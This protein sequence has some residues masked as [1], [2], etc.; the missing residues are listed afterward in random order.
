M[1]FKDI[2]GHNQVKKVLLNAITQ[3]RVA[4]AYLFFGP[5]GIGKRG[6]ATAFAAGILCTT[7]PG[8]A[9]GECSRCRRI[10]EGIYPDVF[11]LS[12]VNGSIKIEQ[13]RGIQKKVQYKPYEGEK[14]VIIIE[15]A[16][17]MTRDAS[18]SLLKILEE[19][20]ED[21]CFILTASNHYNLLPTIVSRCQPI[22]MGK[23][24]ADD[25][26]KLLESRGLDLEKAKLITVFADGIPGR[27]LEMIDSGNLEESRAYVFNLAQAIEKGSVSE[28]LKYAEEL[29]KRGDLQTIL[30]QMVLWYR[31]NLMWLETNKD[32]LIINLDRLNFIKSHKG[33]KQYYIDSIK[34][35]LEA[36]NKIEQNVNLRLTLEVLLLKLADHFVG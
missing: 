17:A 34:E 7:S 21:T 29:E 26:E 9:C 19:P 5:S 8:S 15:D 25:I 1:F 20:P 2:L 23:V 3:N 28:L 22:Q 27:A 13:V 35:I 31:D 16:E 24:P 14:K 10:S 32:N 18:N 33:T 6:M 30:E 36:K 11:I 12:P 4:H